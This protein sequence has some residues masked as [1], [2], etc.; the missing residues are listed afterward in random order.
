MTKAERRRAA[1]LSGPIWPVMFR[2][3]GPAVV[4]TLIMSALSVVERWFLGQIGTVALASVALVFPVFM[5][6]NMLSAGSIGGVMSGATANA[7]GAGNTEQAEMVLRSGFLM[8]G[9]GGVAMALLFRVAGPYFYALQG[10]EGDVLEGAVHYS[11]I[12]M[13]GLPLVWQFNMLSGI[14]RGSGDMLTP[15]LLQAFVTASHFGFCWLF[16]TRLDWGIGGAGWAI[17]AAFALGCIAVAFV[18]MGAR[19]PVKPCIGPIARALIVPLTRMATMA[20]FQAVV[21][22]I[23]IMLIT[24]LIGRLGPVW[25]AG[26]GVGSQMEFLLMPIIFGIGA[27][28]IAMVGANRGAGQTE[29]AIGIA[30][31]GTLL[32]CV[33]VGGIGAVNAIFPTAWGG[34]FSDDPEVIAASAAYMS[35]VAPFYLFFAM[36]T[37]LY[38]SSQAMQTLGVPVVGSVV[39]FVIIAGGGAVLVATDAADPSSIFWLVAA[40]MAIYG[41]FIAVGLRMTAWKPTSA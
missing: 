36:G 33:F 35:R 27:S 40:G 26:Y 32:A 7:L 39:R 19:S 28:L 14:I 9:V 31:R 38:F 13:L 17:F 20:A 24:G 11:A 23:T 3:A 12:L 37:A 16:V 34:F 8:A 41:L 4:S 30:W 22:I 15:A 6:T 29:R 10:G 2:L 21:T 1:M 5:L 25:L 18:L